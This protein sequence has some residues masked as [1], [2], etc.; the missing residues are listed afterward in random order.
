MIVNHFEG[1]GFSFTIDELSYPPKNQWNLGDV[2]SVYGGLDEED[3]DMEDYY[4][5]TDFVDTP[6]GAVA[7]I[8]YSHSLAF[9]AT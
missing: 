6:E 1:K 7:K 9:T 4:K 8:I 3:R 2:I 5:I